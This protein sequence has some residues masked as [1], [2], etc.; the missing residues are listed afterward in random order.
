[1]LKEGFVKRCCLGYNKL[2]FIE[3]EHTQKF[4]EQFNIST[5][6]DL[7]IPV[8]TVQ[9]VKNLFGY[10]YGNLLNLDFMYFVS[11]RQE[12]TNVEILQNLWSGILG[13]WPLFSVSMALSFLAGTVIW[14]LVSDKFINI[15]SNKLFHSDSSNILFI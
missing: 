11:K 8:G 9:R 15:L 10:N 5:R 2:K 1:M 13:T 3:K 4:I 12:K 14:V 6:V 7:V